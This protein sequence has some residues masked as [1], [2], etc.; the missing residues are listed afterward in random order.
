VKKI[1]QKNIERKN[2][3]EK[4]IIC[5]DKGK[6]KKYK[7]KVKEKSEKDTTKKPKRE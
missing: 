7:N 1:T 2:D 4:A 3:L 6:K 5:N